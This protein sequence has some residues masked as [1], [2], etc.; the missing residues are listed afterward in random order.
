MAF[1][2]YHYILTGQRNYTDEV[3][4]VLVAVLTVET[5]LQFHWLLQ[6]S[7]SKS[8]ITALTQRMISTALCG[9]V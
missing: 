3:C 2:N 4:G 8:Y 7:I 1:L 5:D 9:T 6:N